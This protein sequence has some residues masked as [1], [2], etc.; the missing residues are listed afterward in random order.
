MIV[1]EIFKEYGLKEITLID[2]KE[3][4][5]QPYMR[6]YNKYLPNLTIE[7]EQ[8]AYKRA[9]TKSPQARAYPGIV[10]AIKTF[11]SG[12]IKIAVLSSDF[13]ETLLPE[14]EYFGLEGI[15]SKVITDV[16]NKTEGIQKLVK[17]CNFKLE[18]TIFIGDSNHEIEEGQKAGIRTGAVIWGY[19]SKERLKVLKPDYIFN[20]INELKSA[21]L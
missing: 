21:I 18:E 15:F 1:N 20:N 9:L 2:L 7:E 12:G 3:N 8:V 5:E 17:E 19:S 13:P 14:I 6:F 16:H 11:K 10:E 4:W